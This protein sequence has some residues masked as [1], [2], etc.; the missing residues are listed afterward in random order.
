MGVIAGLIRRSDDAFQVL[1]SE[2]YADSRLFADARQ[3]VDA[4]VSSLQRHAA[5]Q[6]KDL[7]QIGPVQRRLP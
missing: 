5:W 4:L 7:N 2:R 6:I 1:D 3:G